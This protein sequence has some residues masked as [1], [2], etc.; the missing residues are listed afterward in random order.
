MKILVTGATGF[1]GRALVSRLL[2]D[3]H[4]VVAWV[5]SPKR[6][7]SQLGAD[8]EL[9]AMGGGASD[10][11]LVE[12]LSRTDA[13]I[14]LAGESLL[15]KR[16]TE[17]RR[18]SLKRSRLELTTRL[19]L[20]MLACKNRPRVLISSSGIGYYGDRG[21]EMLDESSGP[22]RGFLASLSAGWEQAASEAER[23]GV[24]VVRLRIGTVL[25]PEG[26]ALQ[27]LSKIFR[28]GL[29]GRL[30]S[31]RQQMA[32]IHL[33]DLIEIIVAAL[34]DPRYR[35]AI[36]A[37]APNPVTNRELTRELGR[38]LGRWT[39]LAVP[40]LVLRLVLGQAAS[41]L[42][43]SQRAVPA[44]LQ[45]LGF[46]FRFP[47][48]RLALEEIYDPAREPSIQ[49]FRGSGVPLGPGARPRH[50]LLQTTVLDA[51]VERVFP[52]FSRAHNL[53][54]LTPAWMRFQ[55][56]GDAPLTPEAGTT[57]NYRLKLGPFWIRWRTEITEHETGRRFVDL[58]RRG[59]YRLWH[60]EHRFLPEAGGSRTRMEDRVHYSLPLGPI[61][62]VVHRLIV[63]PMLRR[64]FAYRTSAIALRF[65]LADDLKPATNASNSKAA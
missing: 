25:G 65:G 51:P 55:I 36:N 17:R 26:G 13:V 33:H 24:R 43:S 1:I 7:A 52:F 54:L 35:G 20:G 30:G 59:P 28:W 48:L 41:V 4:H 50:L 6:A 21:D 46:S 29:G 61:G 58:Q 56:I 27:P 39:L 37:I 31:G 14:N 8:V 44:R 60:H 23:L 42:L 5:R 9:L 10:E 64:I 19:V 32:W 45:Q 2:R 15:G 62:L 11:R 47:E 53:G 22:G 12:V 57:I 18:R 3:G 34:G 63:S 38:L 40:S 16:W 49:R